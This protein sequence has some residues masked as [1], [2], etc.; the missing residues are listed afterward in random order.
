MK[1]KYIICYSEGKIDIM[2]NKNNSKKIE[3]FTEEEKKAM[4]ERIKEIKAD[5]LEGEAEVLAK[6]SEMNG[7]DRDIAERFHKIIMKNFPE[8]SPRTWYGMPAYSNSKGKVI[9]YLQN[10]QKFKSRYSTIGFSDGA[11]LDEGK[12]WPVAYAIKDLGDD[13]EK[14]IIYLLKRALS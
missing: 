7:K 6:I 12:M 4:R 13:E 14:M 8:L 5:E 1:N 2:G 9:C 3:G 10:S 11:N